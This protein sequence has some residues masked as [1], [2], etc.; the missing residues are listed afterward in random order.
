MKVLMIWHDL[1]SPYTGS[2]LPAFNLLRCLSKKHDF[3]LLAFKEETHENR[4]SYDLSKY[5]EVITPLTITVP[6]SFTKRFIYT[7]KNTFCSQNMFSNNHSFFNFY[8]S[9]KLQEKLKDLLETKKFDMIYTSLSMAHYVQNIDL[10]KVVHTYDPV[11]EAFFRR[12]VSTRNPKAKFF[13][14]G[15]NIKE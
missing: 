2:S 9:P 1:P 7:A 15:Y 6:Q 8:Y 3:T 11:T 13:F 14:G 12:Y 5:C 4:Y 10:P